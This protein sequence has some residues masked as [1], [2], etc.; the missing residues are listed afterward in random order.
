[1]NWWA[2]IWVAG[3][4]VALQ[5]ACAYCQCWQR[6]AS[7]RRKLAEDEAKRYPTVKIVDLP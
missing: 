7:L 5:L 2:F 6:R 4:L 3:F 1:M